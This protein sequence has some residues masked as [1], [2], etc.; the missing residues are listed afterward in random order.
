MR[1]LNISLISFVVALSLI[2]VQVGYGIAKEGLQER[3]LATS[4]QDRSLDESVLDEGKV[5]A[6]SGRVTLIPEENGEVRELT[7]K[8]FIIEISKIG[9][10]KEVE[11]NVDPRDKSIYGP[12]I[13]QKVAH[14]MFTKFPDQT[15]NE[16]SGNVYLYAHRDGESGFFGGLGELENGDVI[17]LYFLGKNYV[18]KVSTSF[19]V[20]PSAAHI[21]TG[22]SPAPALTLQTCHNG[23][24]ER[25]IVKADLVEVI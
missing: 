12:V 10:R 11:P 16:K 13:E 19:I 6:Q 15:V 17:N 8:D 5:A 22:Q 23:I 9:L 25:L 14:G 20:S 3:V 2:A 18:Y 4:V 7:S 24:Q 1:K 21:Y